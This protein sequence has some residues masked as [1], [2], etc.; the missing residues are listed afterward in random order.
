MP[1]MTPRRA[2]LRYRALLLAIV[3]IGMAASTAVAHDFWL[4]P[5]MF[6]VAVSTA[7]H[8]NGRSGLRFPNGN[9]VQPARVADARIIGAS[10]EA[11]ITEMT[12]EGTS[13]RL[14]Q[15][16][17][18]EGQYLIVAALVPRTT[19]T[20]PA[21]LIR[22]LKAEGGAGEA[23]RLE[24]DNVLAGVD[25]VTYAAASYATTIVQVGTGGPRAFSK[26][27]GFPLEFVPMNDPAH[28]HLGDTLHVRV[29][30]AGATVPRISLD[31]TPASDSAVVAGAAP[32]NLM[33]T[34]TADANGV[35]HVPL[36]KAGPW[37][38]RAAFVSK[39]PGSVA[40]EWDVSRSTYVFNVGTRH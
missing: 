40:N 32:V 11:K 16:P 26:A 10:T 14:H 28:L 8:V 33:V 19:R 30:G 21:G 15:K 34:L 6:G 9:P 27:A 31:A 2:R 35:A 1:R 13:L 29:M 37:M 7:I 12:V 23:A 20:A 5:D 39:R 24:R 4:I 36:T 22:Y 3:G 38:L 18:A 17:V 25:T